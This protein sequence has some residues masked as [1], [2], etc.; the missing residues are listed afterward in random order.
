[1]LNNLKLVSYIYDKRTVKE[2]YLLTFCLLLKSSHAKGN[3]MCLGYSNVDFLHSLQCQ[4]NVTWGSLFP[5]SDIELVVVQFLERKEKKCTTLCYLS[6]PMLCVWIISVKSGNFGIF[7]SI[8]WH[9]FVFFSL[10][11]SFI[12]QIRLFFLT[13][14]IYN[15]KIC[16]WLW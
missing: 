7:C 14:Y 11:L 12:I 1:M 9:F 13:I 15:T 4:A 16:V 10:S 8:R 2:L 3:H 5:L 6:Y